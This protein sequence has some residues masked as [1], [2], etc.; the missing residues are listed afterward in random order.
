MTQKI[1][2][3]IVLVHLQTNQIYELNRTGARFWELLTSGLDGT[4][5]RQ[6]MLREFAVV[7]S[8]LD[9]EIEALLSMLVN[10]NLVSTG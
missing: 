5:I 1:G 4:R 9:Q 10:A 8:Q 2:D 6:T 3:R 7:E